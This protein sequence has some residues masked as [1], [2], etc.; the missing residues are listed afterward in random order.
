MILGPEMKSTGEVMGI[1]ASFALAFAKS[2]L[3]AGVG[4]ADGGQGVPLDQGRGQARS[5]ALARRLKEMGFPVLTTRGTGARSR[6]G[7]RSVQW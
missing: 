6:E 2:Q 4:A 1:D 7:G 3:G 5:G